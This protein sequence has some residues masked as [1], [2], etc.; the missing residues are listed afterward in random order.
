MMI[1]FWDNYTKDGAQRREK[2]ASPLQAP[3]EALQG[4]PAALVQTARSDVLRDE[5]EAYARKLN[6]AGVE[7]MAVRYNGLIHDTTRAT[8]AQDCRHVREA[9]ASGVERHQDQ[10]AVPDD[11]NET[12]EGLAPEGL[13]PLERAA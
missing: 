7:A 5:G 13:A 10:P 1:W 6:R 8:H 12:H 2:Y 11:N 4:L 9:P 3:V